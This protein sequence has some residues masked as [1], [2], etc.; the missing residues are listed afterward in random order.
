MQMA[1]TSLN[2]GYRCRR[3]ERR[4]TNR[5]PI[6]AHAWFQWLGADGCLQEG[7]A[8]TLDIS[9]QGVFVQSASL[10]TT[11]ASIEIAVRVPHG[12]AGEVARLQVRGRGKVIRQVD[13]QGFAAQITFHIQRTGF[14]SDQV[15]KGEGR[16]EHP[17]VEANDGCSLPKGGSEW[18]GITWTEL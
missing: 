4:G 1:D 12:K 16:K 11:G 7:N 8:A 6:Q 18:P 9:S 2:D 14:R 10:P 5:Y 15:S 13:N 3:E 17:A